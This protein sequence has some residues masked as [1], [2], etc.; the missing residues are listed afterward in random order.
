[1]GQRNCVISRPPVDAPLTASPT[2]APRQA[3]G[4]VQQ[5][6]ANQ[7]DWESVWLGLSQHPIVQDS[8]GELLGSMTPEAAK[9]LQVRT[10]LPM[11]KH[12]WAAKPAG[13]L[14]AKRAGILAGYRGFAQKKGIEWQADAAKLEARGDAV[15]EAERGSVRRN[16]HMPEYYLACYDGPIHSYNKG[17][18][19]WMAAFDA[20]SAYLLVHLHHYPDVS[21]QAAFDALHEE[22]DKLAL[23][24]LGSIT[25]RPLRCL[26]MG[27]GVGTSTFSTAR[28]LER[29]GSQGKVTGLDLSDYFVTVAKQIQKERKSEFSGAIDI[30]FLHGDALDLKT[31]GFEDGSLDLV[32][33]SEVTHEMPKAV[34][35]A[36]F[37]EA[38]RVLAP[39]GVLGYLDL[40]PAQILKDNPVGALVDR[41]A[42][43]NE[44]YFD[45]YLELDVAAAMRAAGL[46]VVENT[47]PHHAKYPTLESCSLR[48]LVAKKPMD[49]GLSTWTGSWTLD[50]RENWGAYLEALGVPEAAREEATKSPDFHEYQV[51][52]NSFFMDHRIP[53]K[54]V[55][56]RY[57]AFLDNV[58]EVA[59]YQK[60]T[61]KEF[62]DEHTEA[63]QTMWRHRWVKFPTTMETILGEFIGPGKDVSLMRE[64]TGPDEMKMTVTVMDKETGKELVAPCYTWMKRT[65]HQPPK[66]VVL[67]LRERFATGESKSLEWRIAAIKKAG[68]LIA[69]NVE[70]L[71]AAQAQDHV[72]PSNMFGASLMVQGA[73]AFYLSS[74]PSWMAASTPA[75]TVP[76]FMQAGPQEGEWEVLPEPKGVGLV[77]APWNAPALLCVLPLMG[78]LAAGNLCVIKPSEAAPASSRLMARLIAKY[79]P[80]RSVVVVEGGREVV[81]DLIDSPVD[82]ILFTGGGEIAKKISAL[83]ARHLTP[84]SLELGGKNPCFVDVAEPEQLAL[85][86]AEIIGTKSYFGGQFC[87]AMDYCL[88]HEQVFDEF[89]L[90]L[91]EKVKALEDKRACQMINVGHAKRVK[92]L[93]SGLDS[94]L[95]RPAL[96][97]VEEDCVPLTLLIN[98]P[99]DSQIMQH[100][101]FGPLL[102]IVR[103]SSAA[104]AAAF[105]QGRPKPLAAYCYSPN[106]DAWSLFRNKSSSGNLAVNCGPQ[107]MQSNLNV[108]F[109]GVGESGYGYSIWGKA[110]FDDYSHKKAIFKGKNFAGSVWGACPPPPKGAGK[111]K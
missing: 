14:P 16:V 76:P 110:A 71:S 57:T 83:A 80:D 101:I 39:G 94:S 4:Q 55:H 107:R 79:F 43:S 90:L 111:G 69:E 87:Q 67:E 64:L 9:V 106:P 29:A 96:E 18:G 40:N 104:E 81:E 33:I 5:A 97:E 6:F 72:S 109:G 53:A 92:S 37:R 70:A 95:A 46:E 59:A 74:L 93:M 108:G 82:H 61:A 47:W 85:Y 63:K 77:I 75:E 68:A 100:E 26:D 66:N 86:A 23:A 56:M 99:H 34:S 12:S 8:Y 103:V 102:P 62:S 27:C 3:Q 1:M 45:Q 44:P 88:V 28:S 7:A 65:G 50:R 11:A 10:M 89:V 15:W 42:T 24:H 32:V 25:A 35:E 54:S 60:P 98:P 13:A 84:M 38:A 17:N 21:P 58:W 73:V 30:E 105:V 2:Q 20:P 31:C 22:F 19:E 49:L 78:M 41:V 48:F 91:E 52:E 51:T 36:L